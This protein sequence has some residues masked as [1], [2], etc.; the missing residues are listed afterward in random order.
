[1]GDRN[2][3]Q[4]AGNSRVPG[5][6]FRRWSHTGDRLWKAVTGWGQRDQGL[7]A[8][9]R[10]RGLVERETVEAQQH[11]VSNICS[12]RTSCERHSKLEDKL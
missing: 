10:D 11:V 2:W 6:V 12:A 4:V 9:G 7:A 3:G 8:G 1:M 5:T